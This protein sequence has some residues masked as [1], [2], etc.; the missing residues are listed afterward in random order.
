[1]RQNVKT[2]KMSNVFH[3]YYL[4]TFE[5]QKNRMLSEIKAINADRQ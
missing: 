3:I 1:M 2:L 4:N 5:K